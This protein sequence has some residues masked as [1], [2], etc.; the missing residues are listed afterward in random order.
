MVVGTKCI[1][2]DGTYAIDN[3]S[4][5]K[6]RDQNRMNHVFAVATKKC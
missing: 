6:Q 5:T 2:Q 1:S 4:K 3:A